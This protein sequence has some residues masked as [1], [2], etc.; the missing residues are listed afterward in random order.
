LAVIYIVFEDLGSESFRKKAV[1]S[2]LIYR[3]LWAKLIPAFKV[4]LK[5]QKF[6]CSGCR[7]SFYQRARKMGKAALQAYWVIET[8]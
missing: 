5:K 4:G 8:V 2:K 7:K 3:R 6:C 1:G